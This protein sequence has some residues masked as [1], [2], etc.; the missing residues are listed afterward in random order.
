[1]SQF[2]LAILHAGLGEQDKAFSALE[3]AY[4]AHDSQMQYLNIESHFDELRADARF[5]N[6]RQRVSLP[7]IVP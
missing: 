1:M 5:A 2:E 7:A 6:L 4:A 3:R